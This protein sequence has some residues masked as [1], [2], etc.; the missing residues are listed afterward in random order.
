[1][2]NKNVMTPGGGM[3]AWGPWDSATGLH[4]Y[5]YNLTNTFS[6]FFLILLINRETDTS[7]DS[8]QNL[9]SQVLKP[10]LRFKIHCRYRQ[11]GSLAI[12]WRYL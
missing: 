7:V 1:M 2:S 3:L 11:L 12:S 6:D 9:I 10:L 8:P 5:T 4:T